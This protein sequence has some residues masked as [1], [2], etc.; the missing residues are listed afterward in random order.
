MAIERF[1]TFLPDMSD[2]TKGGTLSDVSDV[3]KFL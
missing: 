2:T 1:L 3:L